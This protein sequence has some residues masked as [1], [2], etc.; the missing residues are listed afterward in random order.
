M[1][2]LL[3]YPEKSNST[4]SWLNK[5]GINTR[6]EHS[7]PLELLELSIELPITW[8]KKLIDLN[9]NKL[10][11]KDILW[12]DFIIIK[13]QSNQIESVNSIVLQC[14]VFDKRIIVQGELDESPVWS[15]E[16]RS[17]SNFSEIVNNLFDNSFLD[18]YLDTRIKTK[19]NIGNS[20]YSLFDFS[21]SFRK[22]LQI[23][24]D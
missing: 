8:E 9:E 23:V 13:A 6:K 19:Q 16:Q 11:R 24:L 3:L 4:K 14:S 7:T 1:K 5:L 10:R 22:R 20:E 17:H 18:G 21:G 15:T 12:A 2:T